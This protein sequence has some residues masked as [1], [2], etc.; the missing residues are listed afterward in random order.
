MEVGKAAAKRRC[1]V[2]FAL[3]G[4]PAA[5]AAVGGGFH[6]LAALG[7]EL[8]P[9]EAM[10]A[11]F[12]VDRVPRLTPSAECASISNMSVFV[13]TDRRLHVRVAGAGQ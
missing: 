10:K 2:L 8:F 9:L 6:A 11:E 7:G 3:S 1:D 4:R 5:E 12:R 13:F